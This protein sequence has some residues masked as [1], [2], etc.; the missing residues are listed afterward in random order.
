MSFPDFTDDGDLPVGVYK[1]SLE[2]V[3]QHFGTG[4][5]KRRQVT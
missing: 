3:I 5:A 4:S 1:A 2:E